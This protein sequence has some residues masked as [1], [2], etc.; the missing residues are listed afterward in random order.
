MSAA[1]AERAKKDETTEDTLERQFRPPLKPHPRAFWGMLVLWAAW[2]GVLLAIYF[3]T[4]YP[5][6]NGWKVEQRP[7]AGQVPR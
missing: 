4:V 1:K 3:K 6:W 2:V 5:S 7:P